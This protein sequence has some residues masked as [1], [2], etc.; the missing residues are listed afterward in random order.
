MTTNKINPQPEYVAAEPE[1]IYW[2]EEK[3]PY[4]G[5]KVLLLNKGGVCIVGQWIGELG[6]YFD[7]WCPMP[8]RKHQPPTINQP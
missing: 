2:R 6:Q 5:A 7:A 8:K 3:C 4:P 1:E